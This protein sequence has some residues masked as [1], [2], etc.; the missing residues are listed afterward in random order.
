MSVH[1]ETKHDIAV[2]KLSG[3]FFGGHETDKLREV[4]RVS[5][6]EGNRKLIIDLGGVS[7]INS[8]AIGILVGAHLNYEARGAR[9][10]LA[11]LD[12]QITDTLIITKLA[13]LFEIGPGLPEALAKLAA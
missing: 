6:A 2:L 5:M 11:N 12:K 3:S 9:I 8:T 1:V 7:W 4:L 13:R 10:I